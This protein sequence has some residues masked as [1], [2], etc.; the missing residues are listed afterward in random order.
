MKT[1]VYLNAGN[2]LG[3]SNEIN[4]PARVF[5]STMLDGKGSSRVFNFTSAAAANDAAAGAPS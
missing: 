3:T 2:L 5:Y 4:Q 1:Q